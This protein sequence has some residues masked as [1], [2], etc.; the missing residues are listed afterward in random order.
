MT[1]CRSERIKSTFAVVGRASCSKA[2]WKGLMGNACFRFTSRCRP[3]RPTRNLSQESNSAS[4]RTHTT[5]I[6]RLRQASLKSLKQA[7]KTDPR[8][9]YG[10]H[11]SKMPCKVIKVYDADTVTL[12]FEVPCIQPPPHTMTSYHSCRIIGIDAP[13]LRTADPEE[14]AAAQQGAN[15][16][17]ELIL[18]EIMLMD[19]HGLD[20]YGRPLV[21]LYKSSHSS[22]QVIDTLGSQALSQ[23]ILQ[24]LPKVVPY[25]GGKKVPFDTRV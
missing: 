5:S 3:K 4:S 16:L 17:R 11:V 6:L 21:D 2:M 24:N 22:K 9:H 13:E 20:K 14:K 18:D 15:E 8:V 1:T 10:L 12:A 25:E 19:A 23:W 7:R